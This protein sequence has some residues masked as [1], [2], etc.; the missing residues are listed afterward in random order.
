MIKI[1][2]KGDISPEEYTLIRKANEIE[3]R[4]RAKFEGQSCDID[5]IM[6]DFNN[7]RMVM[8]QRS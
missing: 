8:Q 5:F 2:A 6:A 7:L 1:P 3:L 4:E